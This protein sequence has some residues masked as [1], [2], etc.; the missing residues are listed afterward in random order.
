MYSAKLLDHFEHPRHA[1]TLADATH[2][3]TVENLACG[4]VME[5]SLRV[6]GERIVEVAF[7]AK[8]CVPAMAC[9]SA[10][11][12]WLQGKSLTAAKAVTRQEVLDQVESVPSASN[13]ALDLAVEAVKVALKR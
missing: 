10:V 13:H 4:D 5:L 11:T 2:T 7:K 12:D 9:A 6:E 8:G 3:A 1:G